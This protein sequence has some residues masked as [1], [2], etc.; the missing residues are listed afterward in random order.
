MIPG[1]RSDPRPPCPE[2]MIPGSQSDPR[3]PWYVRS[4]FN[5][6]NIATF[7]S[8]HSACFSFENGKHGNPS[9]GESNRTRQN[10][11]DQD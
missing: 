10:G 5:L 2:T 9:K 4:W 8:E 3:P 7:L 6:G 11:K 1:S